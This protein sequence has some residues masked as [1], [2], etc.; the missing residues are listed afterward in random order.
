MKRATH[1][2]ILKGKSLIRYVFA[3]ADHAPS[4]G[5]ECTPMR[6]GE[7]HGARCSVCDKASAS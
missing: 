7:H 4:L 5:A 2:L 1:I 6:Y 3:C